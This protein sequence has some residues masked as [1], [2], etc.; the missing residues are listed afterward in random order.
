L[1]IVV[2]G[3]GIM[4]RQTWFGKYAST[5][6]RRSSLYQRPDS[7]APKQKSRKT[8]CQLDVASAPAS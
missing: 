7:M 1:G 4:A 6:S 2:E 3:C 8:D 5:A